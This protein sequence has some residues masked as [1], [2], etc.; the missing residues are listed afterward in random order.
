MALIQKNPGPNMTLGFGD[1]ESDSRTCRENDRKV[2]REG[3]G[4]KIENGR[5]CSRGIGRYFR[6]VGDPGVSVMRPTSGVSEDLGITRETK[7]NVCVCLNQ[8]STVGPSFLKLIITFYYRRIKKGESQVK[9][10][11]TRTKMHS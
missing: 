4:E 9:K 10:C 6:G 11:H 8:K 5:W 3:V 1:P 7:R 2:E